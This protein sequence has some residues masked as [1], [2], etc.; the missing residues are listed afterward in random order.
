[1]ARSYVPETGDIVWLEFNPHAG[2]EQSGHRPALVISPS[3][4]N[5]KTGLIHVKAKVKALLQ[6][7]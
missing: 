2:H 1:M 5:S 6:I 4:Y 7:A 3:I